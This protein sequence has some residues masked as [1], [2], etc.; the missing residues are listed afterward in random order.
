VKASRFGD[1][2]DMTNQPNTSPSSRDGLVVDRVRIRV[3][4]VPLRRPIVSNVGIYE[5][6]PFILIDLAT[7]QGV[8]GRSYLE[9]Y[10]L[11]AAK[12][13]VPAIE[14]LAERLRGK[15]VAPIQ[16]FEQALGWL[17][18]HGRQGVGLIATAAIDMALWD[19]LAKSAG[20]P[21]A[22]LLGGTL[23]PVRAYN[24]NGLWL[25]PLERVAAE[26][27][28]LVDEGKFSAIKIRLGRPALEDDLTAL[29][30]VR[31]AVCDGIKLMSDF[32]QGLSFGQ[33][34]HRLHGLDDQGLHWFEEPIVFDNY[35]GCAQLARELKTPLQ[36]GE[37][38]YGP[39]DFY[40]AVKTQASDFYM[41]DLMR[42]GGVT[43]FLRCAAIAGAA[44]LPLS[45]HLY[46]EFSAHL[47]RVCETADWLE[48]REW[49]NPLLK[50]P[51]EV[52][53]GFVVIPDRPGAGIDWDDGAVQRYSA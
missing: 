33:A 2:F 27:R 20:L 3:A 44:G 24:T 38:I 11:D 18:L 13:I 4:S 45:N 49:G 51:F 36:I 48:W 35:D 16:N 8:V 7:K 34:L 29:S 12:Y 23:E 30:E 40:L 50:D 19:A 17:H 32:N 14:A 10:V 31:N 5:Q 15:L 22:V 9:P 43:G 25:I 42:I 1:I 37:N 41:P 39:R 47:L 53:D 46:P 6:W 21:L 52:K 28:E 26:A